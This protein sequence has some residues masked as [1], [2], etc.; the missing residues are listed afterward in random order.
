MRQLPVVTDFNLHGH[1]DG[2]TAPAI[3]DNEED[4]VP[5]P[6]SELLHWHHK[7]GHISFHKL[8]RMAAHEDIPKRLATCKIPMCTACLFGK[9]TKRP[10][11]TKAAPNKIKMVRIDKPEACV[12]V[13]QI[14]STTPGLVGQMKGCFATKRCRCATVFVD[15]HSGLSCPHIQKGTG[16]AEEMVQG[17]RQFEACCATHGVRVQH[18]HADNGRFA[19]KLFDQMIVRRFSVVGGGVCCQKMGFQI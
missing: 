13:D 16:G 8:R 17:K 10:W 7:L 6:Q 1:E 12:S 14:E 4:R 5:D 2:A 18:C 19:E 11:R 15:H 3:V 9:A